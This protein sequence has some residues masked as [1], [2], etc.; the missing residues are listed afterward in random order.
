MAY[1]KK[2]QLIHR[3]ENNYLDFKC[4]LRGVSREYLFKSASRIAAVTEAY[5]YLKTEYEWDEE[6]EIDFYLLFSDPLTI[7]ADAWE[8]RRND[9]TADVGASLM[10][11]DYSTT[12]ITEYPLIEGVNEYIY[13]MD[14]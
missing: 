3:I 9:G 14:E 10:D 6:N 5:E 1:T 2:D 11:I 13:L 7:V 4:S 8:S 12:V